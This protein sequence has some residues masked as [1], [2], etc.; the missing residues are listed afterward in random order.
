MINYPEVSSLKP[1]AATS[2]KLQNDWEQFLEA[3]SFFLFYSF[4]KLENSSIG[5]IFKSLSW[6]FLIFF[7]SAVYKYSAMAAVYAIKLLIMSRRNRKGIKFYYGCFWRVMTLHV[8]RS[9]SF[10]PYN[11]LSFSFFTHSL[12]RQVL[13]I[14]KKY[15]TPLTKKEINTKRK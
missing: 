8:F 12:T 3:V 9:F 11:L 7:R 4:E 14:L 13:A 15:D 6:L 2:P 10:L 5:F 1:K